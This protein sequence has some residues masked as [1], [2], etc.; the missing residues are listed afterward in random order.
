MQKIRI[1]FY[2]D[3][4]INEEL[5]PLQWSIADLKNF[6]LY[7][8]SS[9]AN[10]EIT[11]INRH[12]DRQTNEPV[13]GANKLAW[14]LL[15]KYD[16]LWVFGS[17]LKNVS[18][19]DLEKSE[20]YNELDDYELAVM[21]KWMQ[22]GGLMFTGDHAESTDSSGNCDGGDR[23]N[24]LN[25]GRALGYRIPR[26]RQLRVWQG[27]P[28]NCPDNTDNYNT[29]ECPGNNPCNPNDPGLEFDAKPQTLIDLPAT[30]HQL[31][32]Y[33]NQSGQVVPISVFPDHPHEGKVMAP[34]QGDLN[35]DWPPE[36][37][38][39]VVVARGRDKRFPEP[40]IYDLVVA[41]DGDPVN[42]GRIVADSS[43]HHYLNINLG[44]LQSRDAVQGDP[45]PGTDLDQIA[46]YY[47][48]LALW[49]APK[50]IRDQLQSDLFFRLATNP[51]VLEARG[52]GIINLGKVALYAVKLQVGLANFYH[53]LAPSSLG[54]S[55]SSAGHLLSLAL[56]E[57]PQD[58]SVGGLEIM[59][60]SIMQE[61]HD[62]FA[63]NGFC[64]PGWLEENPAP[65][66]TIE[67]GFVRAFQSQP[68]LI[69]SFSTNFQAATEVFLNNTK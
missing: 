24:F 55:P 8:T 32:S 14:G 64:S 38:L 35:G 21:Q 16:E 17:K 25:R 30:P 45:V 62:F 46:Q 10:I 20:P 49:L 39:P 59:L 41:F 50:A 69:E 37:P 65:A 58:E 22:T 48:N 43:F 52:S 66:D 31:F 7:K 34:G 29:L 68:N 51:D 63:A 44:H 33:V 1:L 12:L 28:T 9:V 26:A 23:Q 53:I 57:P 67:K 15:K 36:S 5:G 6:I 18:N 47:A 60:G 56:L 40:K 54:P 4:I 19:P 42:V 27:P 3:D 13:Q 61:H 2:T 11:F